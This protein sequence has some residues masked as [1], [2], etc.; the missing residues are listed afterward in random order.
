MNPF[1]ITERKK[2]R[3]IKQGLWGLP[4]LNEVFDKNADRYPNK[5]I[6]VDSHTR[7]T[8][9]QAQQ[10]INRLALGLLDLGFKKDDVLIIQLPSCVEAALLRLAAAK[11]GI[12]PL[13][14][15]AAFE[16]NEVKHIL[17]KSDAHGI[18]IPDDYNKRNYYGMIEEI[19]NLFPHLKHVL[20]TGSKVPVG[21][22]S[23][24]KMISRPIEKEYP[25]MILVD[26]S[27]STWEVQ[28]LQTTSGST[29]LPKITEAF[30]WPQLLGYQV[31]ERW[32]MNEND[33][34]GLIVPFAGGIANNFWTAG[35]IGGSKMA[36]LEKF[37]PEEALMFIERE[38]VTIL[39][40]VPAIGEM[41]VKA[42]NIKDYNLSSLRIYFT[43]G[44]PMPASLAEEIEEK[45]ACKVVGLLGSMGFGPISMVSVDDPIE[46]RL[47]TVGNP[48]KGNEVKIIDTEGN[49]VL[50]GEK[51]ELVCRGPYSFT[52]Y[53]KMPDATLDVYGGDKDGWF[54]TGDM[55]KID[56]NGF[57]SVVGRLKDVIKRGAM[58]IVPMEV[59]NLLR[60]HSKVKDISVIGMPDHVLGERVCAFIIPVSDNDRITIDEMITFLR[61]QNLAKYKL[62]ERIEFIEEFPLVGGQ[63]VNKKK[64]IEIITNK[65]QMEEEIRQGA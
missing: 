17:Q 52:G 47:N 22:L 8:F 44:A 25:P 56:E 40:G 19:R 15:M 41:L 26:K 54:R 31:S 10:S 65:L 14:I 46:V 1:L 48:L 36:F 2:D 7:L 20:V 43:A 62:P 59:E 5:E 32:N 38:N 55:A 37:S 23:V 64:L 63:K 29:G 12:L 57:L 24:T 27:I 49:E 39:V 6:L 45:M 60:N 53:F 33:V 35:I 30:G 18:V 16:K 4:T 21:C 51:G 9:E 61:E 13:L 11:A 58:S 34:L 42:Q 3:Y 28:E 50:Q